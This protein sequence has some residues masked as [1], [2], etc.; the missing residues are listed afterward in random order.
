M[1]LITN[2]S[3]GIQAMTWTITV[4]NSSPRCNCIIFVILGEDRMDEG[5]AVDCLLETLPRD[6]SDFVN[7]DNDAFRQ[8]IIT[9]D[10]EQLEKQR[11]ALE[12]AAAAKIQKQQQQTEPMSTSD[13][14]ND[15]QVS[16]HISS[17]PKKRHQK[18][19]RF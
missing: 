5:K 7:S 4:Q 6:L 3:F 15:V 18:N 10:K 9:W 2:F 1:A 19:K 13:P 14:N 17:H 8:E 12:A 16:K 11:A